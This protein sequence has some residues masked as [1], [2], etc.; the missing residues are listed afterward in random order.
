MIQTTTARASTRAWVGDAL[1]VE[2][3]ADLR[4]AGNV[5]WEGPADEVP[6]RPRDAADE[7]GEQHE[8]TE[9]LGDAGEAGHGLPPCSAVAVP[10]PETVM[11]SIPAKERI[12]VGWLMV[13]VTVTCSPFT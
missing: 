11:W 13:T 12:W 8:G 3:P 9:T 7:G 5:V 6:Q 2:G 1:A 4:R 10:V